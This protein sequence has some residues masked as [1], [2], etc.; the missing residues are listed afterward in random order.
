MSFPKVEQTGDI[1]PGHS[2]IWTTTGVIQDGGP[3]GGGSGPTPPPTPGSSAT[4]LLFFSTPAAAEAGTIPDNTNFVS[5]AGF[6]A[7]GDGG[8]ATYQR[9]NSLPS[10]YVGDGSTKPLVPPSFTS[11]G[12]PILCFATTRDTYV[13]HSGIVGPITQPIIAGCLAFFTVTYW[14]TSPPASINDSVGNVYLKAVDA[15]RGGDGFSFAGIYYCVNPV[16]APIGT[17][18]T[19]PFGNHQFC[20]YTVPGFT[21][22]VLDQVGSSLDINPNTGATV[23]TPTLTASPSLA[24]GAVYSGGNAANTSIGPATIVLPVGWTDIAPPITYGDPIA[25][26]VTSSTSPVTFN[27]TW[28]SFNTPG[29]EG[30]YSVLATFKTF[31]RA[32]LDP[33]FWS[34]L[35]T[36]PLHTAQYGIDPTA[37][38]NLIPF[39]NFG[40]YLAT[41][42]A[43]SGGINQGGAGTPA[44]GTV[45][46]SIGNPA[47]ITV[48]LDTRIDSHNLHSGMMISFSTTGSLP[49]GIVAGQIYYVQYGSVTPT[50]FQI[51]A[52]S[53]FNAN[54]PNGG[55]QTVL[56]GPS[57]ATSGSQSGVHSY[58][59]YGQSWTDFI[60]DPGIYSASVNQ[61]LG[62]GVGLQKWRLFGYGARLETNVDF[63]A[64]CDN[65]INAA[66]GG[67]T[68]SF[69]AQFNTTIEATNSGNFNNYVIL[70]TPSQAINFYVNSWVALMCVEQQSSA[71][72]NWNPAIFEFAKVQTVD[73]ITGII[74]FWDRIQYNYR[75]TYPK[76]RSQSFALTGSQT[77]SATIVQLSD[78]F[79]QEVEIHG[80]NLFGVTEET[81][82]GVFSMK[83]I[84]CDIWGWAFD[85]GPSPVL[86]RRYEVLNCRFHNCVP[87]ID[88]MI[89]YMRYADC[90]FDQTSFMRF[91]SASIN[92]VVVERCKMMGGLS[93]TPKDLTIRDS[94]IAGTF[95]YGPVYGSTQRMTLVNTH[96]ERILNNDQ[97]TETLPTA[98]SGIS[99]VN[100][101]IKIASGTTTIYGLWNGPDTVSITPAPWAQPGAKIVIEAS[102]AVTTGGAVKPTTSGGTC[103]M[104]TCFTVLDVYTDGSG[105][106]C[107]DTDIAALPNTA[108]TITGTIAAGVLTVASTSPVGA[109]PLR[110]MF[111]TGGTLPAGT[112]I[113]TD[114]GGMPGAVTGGF[115]LSGSPPNNGTPTAYTVALPMNFL[116][117][118]CPRLTMINCTGGRWATDM[119]GAPPDIPM[120]S[121]FKRAY[122]GTTLSTNTNDRSLYLAGNLLSWTINVLKPYTGAGATYVCQFSIGGYA[123]SGGITY[124]T[125]ITQSIDLKTTG[126]RTITATAVTGSAGADSIAAIP[127]FISGT[128]AVSIGI[129]TAF[130]PNPA[131][132]MANM[133]FFIMTAQTDQGIDF[134]TMTVNTQTG[135]RPAGTIDTF[136]DTTTLTAQP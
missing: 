66:T 70:T 34:L 128:H 95:T 94:F 39:Q 1:T 133:P 65:D 125:F 118:P 119:A 83:F 104:I 61:G 136:A 68:F 91:Q 58:T 53:I 82:G 43:P 100:G 131:D 99:F 8:A 121:Y 25:C 113:T 55:Q 98:F 85:S 116:P 126:L 49:T 45:S 117:H 46:I 27:P 77:G 130:T 12:L 21:G 35:P 109:F 57:V 31:P 111:L 123:T 115:T 18:F 41:I 37:P 6:K 114:N 103:G 84:D 29:A 102:A 59:T 50:T 74:T 44:I 129:P 108:M 47:V 89:D 73:P 38:D 36:S 67:S 16:F 93:G 63:F 87:E 23:T 2:V 42:A 13:N 5:V 101:T 105:N 62:M 92:K 132:T 64:S 112:F 110:G 69:T 26:F 40:N 24:I 3:S 134:A 122:A 54:S 107:I 4:G 96:I 20:I 14:G 76:F 75:S 32:V 72:G 120:F 81:V 127:F 79:D 15:H 97:A 17:T 78:V 60:L 86:V 33:S 22:A 10:L 51:S 30:A 11:G 28:A 90:D 48:T 7:P 19:V 52:T 9:V 71:D 135:A 124:P 80:L 88:K 106:F 56:K